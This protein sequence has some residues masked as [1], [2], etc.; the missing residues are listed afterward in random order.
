MQT[1][2]QTTVH[3]PLS[4]KS[5]DLSIEYK[6]S[7]AHC[8]R[9]E[10]DSVDRVEVEDVE[11]TNQTPSNGNDATIVHYMCQ[12]C[13]DNRQTE[14]CTHV[15]D[16]IPHWTSVGEKPRRKEEDDEFVKVPAIEQPE[17]AA[18]VMRTDAD[19][20]IS[21]S[22]AAPSDDEFISQLCRNNY[23]SLWGNLPVQ[24]NIHLR[25]QTLKPKQDDSGTIDDV[26]FKK[27]KCWYPQSDNDIGCSLVYLSKWLIEKCENCKQGGFSFQFGFGFE[28]DNRLKVLAL[29]SL[30]EGAKCRKFFI[31]GDFYIFRNEPDKERIYIYW[32]IDNVAKQLYASYSG[33]A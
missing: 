27:M 8:Y 4:K 13:L 11:P 3:T 28:Q 20:P 24:S 32:V 15:L 26:V 23:V 9:N 17:K 16:A 2:A 14:P 30:L 21:S 10:Y 18:G 22:S 5:M 19:V 7:A 6:H 31:E 12:L 33:C 1:N 29:K 25:A